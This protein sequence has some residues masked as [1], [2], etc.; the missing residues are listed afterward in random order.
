LTRKEKS[1]WNWEQSQKQEPDSYE[2][3][4]F[5]SISSSGRTNPLMIPHGG[6]RILYRSIQNYSS[7]EDNAFRKERGILGPYNTSDSPITIVIVSLIVIIVPLLSPY[8]YYC[9]L[10]LLL[11]CQ[12]DYIMAP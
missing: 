9:A 8:C 1:Y 12:L 2:I 3:D 4:Q 5:W 6:I 11:L 10:M 7:I